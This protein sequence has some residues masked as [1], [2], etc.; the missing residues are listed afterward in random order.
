MS[1]P[2][3]GSSDSDEAGDVYGESL[4]IHR[5][6]RDARRE[7]Q[8]AIAL[9]IVG[10]LTGV[11]LLWLARHSLRTSLAADIAITLGHGLI[12][13]TLVVAAVAAWY[14]YRKASPS[15]LSKDLIEDVNVIGAIV[16]N[17]MRR[18]QDLLAETLG[19]KAEPASE[20]E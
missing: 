9:A 16:D 13:A 2:R 11:V 12:S 20:E 19:D 1:I 15:R 18:N 7:L 17:R 8:F 3:Q 6:H 14:G 5:A 10:V 4:R